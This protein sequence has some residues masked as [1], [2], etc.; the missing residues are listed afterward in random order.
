MSNIRRA[1]PVLRNS[2]NRRSTEGDDNEQP[3]LSE[4][5][6]YN[7]EEILAL[8]RRIQSSISAAEAAASKVGTNNAS[9]ESVL[10]VLRQSRK[11]VKGKTSY[12]EGSTRLSESENKQKKVERIDSVSNEEKIS[13]PPSNFVKRSPI[14]S[15]HVE[16]VEDDVTSAT[17]GEDL[18]SATDPE[19]LETMKLAELKELAKS[20]GVKGYS[21]LK[22]AE[23]I[24]LL[25]TS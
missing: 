12:R 17:D 6:T 11:Q 21:K 5:K 25:K 24:E 14:P 16:R 18:T 1:R 2:V 15:V 4:G 10:E 9:A 13:R 8:F 23:L 3:H 7:K 19:D 22:K 20:R